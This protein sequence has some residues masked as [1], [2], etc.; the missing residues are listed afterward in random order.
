MTQQPPAFFSSTSESVRQPPYGLIRVVIADDD[1]DTVLTL[2]ALL[3]DAGYETRA[4]YS[5][6]DV[7][8]VA[9]SFGADAVLLD[10]G[11]PGKSGY[12]VARALREKHGA[13]VPL[14]IAV[15]GWKQS[16]DRLLAQLAGFHHHVPKPYD[17]QHILTLL[18]P[19]R[20]RLP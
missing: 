7:E 18:A 19:L 15:T 9:W 16:S 14:L 1:R 17:A 3:R 4:V 8:E 10:I 6:Q 20:A 5:G 11:M 13:T 12:E 2:T